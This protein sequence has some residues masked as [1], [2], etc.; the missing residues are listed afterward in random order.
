M[1]RGEEEAFRFERSFKCVTALKI[2]VDRI[3]R[4]NVAIIE[5]VN[6]IAFEGGTSCNL[7]LDSIV[8]GQR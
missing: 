8:L 2:I 3:G 7:R 5:A 6:F 4:A 1:S